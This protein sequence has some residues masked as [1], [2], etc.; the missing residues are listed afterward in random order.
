M[1]GAQSIKRKSLVLLHV[2]CRSILNKSLDF[3][4]L[5]GTYNLG[6]ITGTESR[7]REEI[8]NAKIFRDDYTTTKKDRNT[9][10][11]G[12]FICVKIT[13]L[14]WNYGWTSILR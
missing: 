6:V 14:V 4:N 2:N 13:F 8:S 12:V 1:R 7:L 3:W 10:G 11:V 9:R 5:I